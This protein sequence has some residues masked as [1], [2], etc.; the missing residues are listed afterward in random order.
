MAVTEEA[1]QGGRN[2]GGMSAR[3]AARVV[4]SVWASTLLA[5]A[6]TLLLASLN[7][8]TSSVLVSAVLSVAIFAFYTIGALVASRRPE[9]PIGWLFCCG[10]FIWGVGELA[11]EYGATRCSPPP[12]HSPRGN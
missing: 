1:M 5:T 4:W 7:A 12:V 3:V 9:N 10:A 8:P 2:A 6:P 11:L